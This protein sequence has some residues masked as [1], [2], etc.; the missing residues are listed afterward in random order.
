MLF[1]SKTAIMDTLQHFVRQ[2]NY[3]KAFVSTFKTQTISAI[4][5]SSPHLRN[6]TSRKS[7]LHMQSPFS[8]IITLLS[9]AYLSN[10]RESSL[11]LTATAPR[12]FAAKKLTQQQRP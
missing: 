6:V 7:L 9:T 8:V 11:S 1:R 12:C 5:T 4:I 10:I 2:F 3:L